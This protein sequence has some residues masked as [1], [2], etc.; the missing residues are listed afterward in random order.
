MWAFSWALPPRRL[1]LCPMS[2]KI[3][4]TPVGVEIL[5]ILFMQVGVFCGVAGRGWL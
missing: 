4:V 3:R 5:E 2:R 1:L